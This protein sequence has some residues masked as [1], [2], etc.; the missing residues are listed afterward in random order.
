MKAKIVRIGNSRGLRIP[1]K[2]LQEY[3]IEDTIEMNLLEEGILL[4]PVKK[5]REGWDEAFKKMAAEG[6]DELLINDVFEDETF[7][8]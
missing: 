3:S 4:Q 7:D 1:K 5:V 2:V 8:F 6:D